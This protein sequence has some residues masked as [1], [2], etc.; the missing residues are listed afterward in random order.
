M[1]KVYDDILTQSQIE[2]VAKNF[3][4]MNFAWYWMTNE[5]QYSCTQKTIDKNADENTDE[6]PILCHSFIM[7]GKPCSDYL[8]VVDTMQKIFCDKTGFKHLGIFRCKLNLQFKDA[9]YNENNYLCPHLDQDYTHKVLIYYP[10]TT[11]GDTF[12]LEKVDDK[13][14]KTIKRVKPIAGRFLL[15]D[16]DT[17][18]AG[19][20]PIK[21]ETRMSLNYNF[22]IV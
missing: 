11:D 9:N 18:H 7:D 3:F 5:H 2:E 21:N 1:Y 20:P 10:Y 17:Y 8:N 14:Y 22:K 13:K 15:M 16:G 12:I 6:R 19:Q 4:N